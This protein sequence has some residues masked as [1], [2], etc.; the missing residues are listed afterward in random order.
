MAIRTL[1]SILVIAFLCA[2]QTHAFLPRQQVRQQVQAATAAVAAVAAVAAAG[3]TLDGDKNKQVSALRAKGNALVSGEGGHYRNKLNGWP[4]PLFGI[5][6]VIFDSTTC[7]LS[8]ASDFTQVGYFECSTFGLASCALNQGYLFL[9]NQMPQMFYV[10]CE[11]PS[12][13]DVGTSLYF[14][15]WSDN[16]C[17][18]ALSVFNSNP[19][20]VAKNTECLSPVSTLGTQTS[21]RVVG[22]RGSASAS[23]GVRGTDFPGMTAR[24]YFNEY[25]DGC[26]NTTMQFGYL[27][28]KT[29]GFDACYGPY[30]IMGLK[31]YVNCGIIGPTQNIG[32]FHTYLDDQCLQPTSP[33][34]VQCCGTQSVSGDLGQ[35][36]TTSSVGQGPYYQKFTEENI[37]ASNPASLPQALVL[38]LALCATILTLSLA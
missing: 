32:V 37:N 22:G 2:S 10:T 16:S 12:S 4:I 27:A 36:E 23:V 35:C 20:L 25:N 21:L 34:Y 38:I 17:T 33:G 29:Q 1:Q 3:Q 30:F 8:P 19:N 15:T 26:S 14:K 11:E 28:C 24:F 31:Y 5:S 18:K 7:P 6:G 13:N 9:P